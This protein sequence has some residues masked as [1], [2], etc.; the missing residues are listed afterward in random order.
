MAQNHHHNLFSSD[1]E[2]DDFQW[3]DHS[4]FPTI[5]RVNADDQAYE[6]DEFGLPLRKGVFQTG[7]PQ[8]EF[9]QTSPVMQNG[10]RRSRNTESAIGSGATRSAV[11][12]KRSRQKHEVDDE[13]MLHDNGNNTTYYGYEPYDP[14]VSSDAEIARHLQDEEYQAKMLPPAPR[15][16][17]AGATGR[18]VRADPSKRKSRMEIVD[19]RLRDPRVRKQLKKFKKK[20]AYFVWI[21]SLAQIIMAIALFPINANLTGSIIETDPFNFM[22][23][24]SALV[25]LEEFCH[26]IV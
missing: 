16:G 3:K 12:R 7:Q 2:D 24:P 26:L 9:I 15:D 8:Q 23:G 25:I 19:D 18:N 11:T 21:I 13:V 20:P 14:N 6:L 4:F 10:N 17:R 5:E 1:E 22:I